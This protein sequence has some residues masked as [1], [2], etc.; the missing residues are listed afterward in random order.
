MYTESCH[1]WLKI[2]QWPST[3]LRVEVWSLTLGP[4]A[5]TG[6]ASDSLHPEPVAPPLSLEATATLVT[7]YT[8]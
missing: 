8:E 1:P 3:A 5:L 2:L 6:P 4:K 7:F